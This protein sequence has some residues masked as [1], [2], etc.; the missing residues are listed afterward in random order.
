MDALRD[1]VLLIHVIG[2]VG[3]GYYLLFPIIFRTVCKLSGASLGDAL[4]GMYTLCRIMQYLL[5]AQL[6]T[7]G[8]IMG[9]RYSWLWMSLTIG[10]LV[11]I[12]AI[13]GMMNAR[14]KKAVKAFGSGESGEQHFAAI[15]GMSWVVSLSLLLILYVMMNPQFG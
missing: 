15:R 13:S 5:I 4:S 3:L 7:G 14:V 8:Y 11:F 9:D 6:L 10:L 2:A 12:G 1:I